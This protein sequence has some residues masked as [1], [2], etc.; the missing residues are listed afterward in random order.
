MPEEMKLKLF[1]KMLQLEHLAE[2]ELFDKIDYYE[3]AEGAFK[4]LGVIGLEREY[5]KW[6][7]GK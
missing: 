6:S 7:Y 1:E 3:Q 2:M 5:L 4:M